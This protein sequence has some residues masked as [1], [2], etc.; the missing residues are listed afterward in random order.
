MSFKKGS[1]ED[2][3]DSQ[4]SLLCVSI[5]KG[6]YNE[7]QQRDINNK[8]HYQV[9]GLTDPELEMVTRYYMIFYII[10]F[11]SL[12]CTIIIVLKTRKQS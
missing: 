7:E 3:I 9:T 11:S 2:I 8:S 5:V 10:S 1:T 6:E 12:S 4:R